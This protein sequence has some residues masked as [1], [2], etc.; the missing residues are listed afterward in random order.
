VRLIR[1]DSRPLP[2]SWIPK[3]AFNSLSLL[4]FLVI[5]FV[6]VIDDVDSKWTLW[7]VQVD[8]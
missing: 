7:L 4:F 3:L 8:V 2:S 5:V 1:R 6:L